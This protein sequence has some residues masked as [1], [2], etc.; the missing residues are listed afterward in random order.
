MAA[1]AR[2]CRCLNFFAELGERFGLQEKETLGLINGS[3][4]SAALIAD[5]ALAARAR[6]ELAHEIFA[7]LIEAF[8]A[9]FDAYA[10]ALDQLWGEADEA[11]ALQ[12]LRHLLEGAVGERRSYQAPVSFRIVPRHLGGALR[13]LRQAG[14]AATVSRAAVTDNPVYVPPDADH[15]LGQILSNGGYQNTMA[16]PALDELAASWADLCRLAERQ[17]HKLLDGRISQL[18]DGLLTRKDDDRY[19]GTLPMAMVGYGEAARHAA[20]RTFLPG[21]ESGGFGQNDVAS[22]T[23]LAWTR[24]RDAGE[25]LTACLAVLAM[26]ASQA[27]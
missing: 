23:F 11:D 2:F 26:I 25:A 7:L 5:A 3:P 6:I 22:L 12:R 15:P 13:A 8:K 14:Q 17:A 27:L 16:Y 9:P 18:P 19:M 4:V 21:S 20:Q 10:P 24:E 1:P